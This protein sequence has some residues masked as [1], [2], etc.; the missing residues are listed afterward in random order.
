MNELIEVLLAIIPEIAVAA[1][2]ILAR[3]VH[4]AHHHVS[5]EVP[6]QLVKLV[7]QAHA[8]QPVDMEWDIAVSREMNR[9]LCAPLTD[10]QLDMLEAAEAGVF[11]R[12]VFCYLVS[13]SYKRG[14][15]SGVV[16]TSV[17]LHSRYSKNDVAYPR[18]KLKIV[19]RQAGGKYP[20]YRWEVASVEQ[21]K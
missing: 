12:S 20:N 2:V 4:Y 3:R 15:L 21:I 19:V 10:E 18:T 11:S 5:R 14:E 6:Q 9:A 7:K 17:T 13:S 1:I 8:E 16:E